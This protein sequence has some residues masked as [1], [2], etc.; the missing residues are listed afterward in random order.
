MP[1]A[2]QYG[3]PLFI[4]DN[5]DVAVKCHTEGHHVGQS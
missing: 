1:C 2:S 3:V 4:N 5:V